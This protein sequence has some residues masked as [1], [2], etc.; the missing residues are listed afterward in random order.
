MKKKNHF[1][2]FKSNQIYERYRL[3]EE[4]IIILPQNYLP[5]FPDSTLSDNVKYFYK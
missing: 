3:I 2:T 5:I 4:Y 1:N